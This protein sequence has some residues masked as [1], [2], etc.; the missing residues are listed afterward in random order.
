MNF[1]KAQEHL[2]FARYGIG[3]RSNTPVQAQHPSTITKIELQPQW[4]GYVG[5]PEGTLCQ[6]PTDALNAMRLISDLL[7]YDT[8]CKRRPRTY[9]PEEFA[10]AKSMT[11]DARAY[12]PLTKAQ[13]MFLLGRLSGYRYVLGIDDDPAVNPGG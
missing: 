5:D 1:N 12:C 13:R 6:S 2:G 10:F 9:T 7:R 3:S 4:E 11:F 8:N